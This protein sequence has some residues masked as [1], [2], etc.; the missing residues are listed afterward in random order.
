MAVSTTH[1]RVL[2]DLDGVTAGYSVTFQFFAEGDLSV[3]YGTTGDETTLSLGSDYT[4]AAR[5]SDLPALG[6]I[7]LA[8]PGSLTGKLQIRRS[9]P[10]TQGLDLSASGPQDPEAYEDALDR[11]MLIAQELDQNDPPTGT[12]FVHGN[13]GGG[14]LHAVATNSVNGFYAAADK[15]LNDAHRASV[16]NP[17]AVTYT[18]VGATP[19]AHASATTN[20]HGI[21]DTADLLVTGDLNAIAYDV[22]RYGAVGN[23]S[24]DDT[25][26]IQAAIDAAAG[27]GGGVVFFPPGTYLVSGDASD[28]HIFTITNNGLTFRGSGR[29][30]SIVK[31][32]SA[33]GAGHIVFHVDGASR[34]RFEDL[35]F[36]AHAASN[37]SEAI[38]LDGATD[39]HVLRCW[40]SALF[41]RSV[42]VMGDSQRNHILQIE[43]DG[44][45]D[46][47]NIEINASS[48]TVVAD[49]NITSTGGNG[50]EV[51]DNA[52]G[53]TI[54]NTIR[55]NWFHGASA[56]GVASFGSVDTLIE[57]NTVE[58]G[59]TAGIYATNSEETPA[60]GGGGL[61]I[62]GNRIRDT[63]VGATAG[64]YVTDSNGG[65][66][67]TDVTIQANHVTGSGD[68]TNVPG[69]LVSGTG[70]TRASLEGNVSSLNGGAGISIEHVRASVIG[71]ICMN[72]SKVG[73]GSQNG[74]SVGAGSATADAVVIGNECSDTQGTHKQQF[75][76]YI[77]ASAT[78]AVVIG[79]RAFGTTSWGIFD[80]GTS[81][82]KQHNRQD[83]AA[84]S[85]LTNSVAAAGAQLRTTVAY[86]A[87]MTPNA[88]TGNEFV[89][90]ATDNVNFTVVTATNG[91]TGQ[92]ITI[93]IRN[94]AGTALGTATWGGGYKMAA[95][96]QPAD[97]NSR[98]IDFQYDGTAWIEVSRTPS[99][100]PN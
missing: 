77:G 70:V 14:A 37:S 21:T 29:K 38:R 96:T 19:L 95:W 97:A 54:G 63:A 9:T 58:G 81:T 99:D 16:A 18:Q 4:V 62:R 49:C 2:Y 67:P 25:D 51:Y 76:V 48:Y 44:T 35:G 90:T 11:A 53:D 50:V 72:N 20:V 73:V 7:T 3:T 85:L 68:S 24:T 66:G 41:G 91:T 46:S 84:S 82:T 64:I 92:R 40:M 45:T 83:F 65:D 71:N 34:D 30:V 93:R 17:H 87:S 60:T 33:M 78:N 28:S 43:S 61:L 69:I 80:S 31:S 15:V 55:G 56:S 13:L 12:D 8:S 1:E 23:G 86:S 27:A 89:I 94:T 59:T 57:G 52:G 22:K 74:I 100:V 6:T 79:N 26:A 42:F 88:L 10:R 32:S 98:A 5:P 36:T 39:C 75:G 47:N